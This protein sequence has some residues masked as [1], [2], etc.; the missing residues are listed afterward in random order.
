VGPNA[1]GPRLSLSQIFRKP[2][3]LELVS[4][5]LAN[6]PG[7]VI[8]PKTRKNNTLIFIFS[9]RSIIIGFRYVIVFYDTSERTED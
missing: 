6:V 8:V 5:V 1:S 4:K 2:E 7:K 3:V 9:L